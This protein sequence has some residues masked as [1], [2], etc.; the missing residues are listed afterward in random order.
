[1]F[2]WALFLDFAWGLLICCSDAYILP[3]RQT[4][5]H[6]EYV[7][8]SERMLDSTDIG[9]FAE[10]NMQHP[11]IPKR[12]KALDLFSKSAMYGKYTGQPIDGDSLSWEQLEKETEKVIEVM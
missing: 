9:K 6:R 8:E 7:R 10:F 11:I 3:A 2:I 1:M 4:F 12:I 5:C